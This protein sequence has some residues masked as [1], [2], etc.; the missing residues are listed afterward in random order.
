MR[1]LQDRSYGFKRRTE[2]TVLKGGSLGNSE[3]H[4][5]PALPS[6]AR[7]SPAE[8]KWKPEVEEV[9]VVCEGSLPKHRAGWAQSL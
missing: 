1:R 3:P 9:D 5:P 2:V 7:A 4:F 6:L 8:S